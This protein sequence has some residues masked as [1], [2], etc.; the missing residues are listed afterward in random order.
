M[1]SSVGLRRGKIPRFCHIV[2]RHVA[3]SRAYG[4][5]LNEISQSIFFAVMLD[6]ISAI[7]LGRN[8]GLNCSF[9]QRFT[10]GICVIA[11]VGQQRI[12]LLADHAQQRAEALDIAHLAWRQDKPDRAAFGIAS[13]MP[14]VAQRRYRR[15]TL[16]QLPYS[17]GRCRHCQPVRAIHIIPSKYNRLSYAGRQLRSCSGGNS[18][19]MI[20]HSSSEKPIRLPNTVS[21]RQR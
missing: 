20:N 11:F 18:I 15:K 13:N 19:P 10:G 21:K 12:N 4:I 9:R 17:S 1:V 14:V 16:F 6:G 2:W 7:A 5:A 8:D 3:N